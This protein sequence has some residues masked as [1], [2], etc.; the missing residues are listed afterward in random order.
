MWRRRIAKKV[1][2][3]DID[4]TLGLPRTPIPDEIAVLL[5][6]VLKRFEVCIIS[7]QNFDQFLAQVINRLDVPEPSLLRHLHCFPAQGTQ[8]YRFTDHWE[9]AYCHYLLSEQVEEVSEVLEKA[10]RELGYWDESIIEKGDS[11]LDNKKTQITFAGLG[12]KAKY[13]DKC[14]WDPNCAKRN[15]IIAR[16]EELA[17]GYEYKLGGTT[18][19]DV[20][21]QGMDKSFGMC[22]LM[23]VLRVKKSDILYFG[24]M[25]QPG[26]NDYPIVA[27]GIDTITVHEYNGTIYALEGLLGILA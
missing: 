17:P 23:R 24:D 3:F 4:H 10:A 19:I 7:G 2:A 18:S 26:G 25:T 13:E 9:K 21:E 14:A 20:T 12:L 6:E 11:L 27:M 22:N 1:L 5:V 16:C 15:A 8:Y